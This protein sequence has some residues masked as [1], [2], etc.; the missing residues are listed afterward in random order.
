[1]KVNLPPSSVPTHSWPHVRSR[2]VAPARPP[3]VAKVFVIVVEVEVLAAR[4]APV[5]VSPDGERERLGEV[6]VT[7]ARAWIDDTSLAG[8]VAASQ[9]AQL[10]EQ[11]RLV[12]QLELACV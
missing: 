11:D 2:P 7:L 10:P 6:T 1:M 9:P 12:V 4:S 5:A 3:I 8:G